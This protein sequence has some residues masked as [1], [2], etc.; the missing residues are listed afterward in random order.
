MAG[1]DANWKPKNDAGSPS[2][3]SDGDSPSDERSTCEEPDVGTARV[4]I[5]PCR[6]SL[7]LSQGLLGSDV[8]VT[9]SQL[10]AR[11]LAGRACT[12][13]PPAGA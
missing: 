8:C 9:K 11:L 1:S 4:P 2:V 6:I 12:Y 7:E 3:R 10:W 13:I 5:M